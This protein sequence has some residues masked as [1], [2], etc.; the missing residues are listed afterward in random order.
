MVRATQGPLVTCLCRGIHPRAGS[1]CSGCGAADMGRNCWET[2]VSPCCQ[3]SRDS[4]E[5]CPVFGAA[6]RARCRVQPVRVILNNGTMIDGNVSLPEGHR[7]SDTLN[8]S[9]RAYIPVTS[10][11]VT[12][13]SPAGA[14]ATRHEVVFV[15]QQAVS[16][17]QPMETPPEG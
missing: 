10:V 16:L 1:S 5:T 8:A 12:A 3:M 11:T 4:C 13:A 17:I 15:S 2:A 6:K 14:P 7:L 9:D